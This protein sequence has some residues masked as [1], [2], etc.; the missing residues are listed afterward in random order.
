MKKKKERSAGRPRPR[1]ERIDRK[2]QPK[3]GRKKKNRL[4]SKVSTKTK[5]AKRPRKST[6]KMKNST[7]GRKLL[8]FSASR[9]SSSSERSFTL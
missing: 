9:L 4:G 8:T 6:D 2:K 1:Q 5:L 7:F 3:K